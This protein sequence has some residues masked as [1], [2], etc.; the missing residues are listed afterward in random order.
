[1]LAQKLIMNVASAFA[2]NAT[3]ELSVTFP[4]VQMVASLHLFQSPFKLAKESGLALS[5][6]YSASLITLNLKD[7]W[8][9]SFMQRHF[10]IDRLTRNI[11]I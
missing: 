4:T 3:N 8:I 9:L 7:G 1:M 10:L 5:T 6:V 11:T 2:Y